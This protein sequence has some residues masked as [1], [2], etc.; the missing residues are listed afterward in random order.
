[1]RLRYDKT[2]GKC[3]EVLPEGTTTIQAPIISDS[4]GFCEHQYEEME[5]HRVKNGHTDIEF[6]RDPKVPEFIQV[7][8]GSE[9]AKRRY[10]K[11]RGF[12]DNN[13]RNGSKAMFNEDIMREAERMMREKYPV[14]QGP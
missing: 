7:K 4:L 5:V 14:K 1:M 3:V 12:S 10:M 8:C 13:T 2:L 9:E 6:V 11:T